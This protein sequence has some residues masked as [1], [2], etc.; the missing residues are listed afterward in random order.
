M[1][2]RKKKSTIKYTCSQCGEIHNDWPA[3]TY[4]APWHYHQLSEKEKDEIAHLDSDLCE[5]R[6]EEQTDLFIRTVLV[7]PVKEFE[8]DLEYGLWVSLSESNFIEYDENFE[9]N[10][11]ETVYFG[12]ICN[13]LIGYDSTVQVPTDVRVKKGTQRPIL[14]LHRNHDHPLVLDFLNGITKEEAE[15]RIHETL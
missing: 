3:I 13:N 11:F 14:E 9:S 5:I 1:I 8:F 12:W 15:K 6:W 4:N 7:I 2:W 10:D